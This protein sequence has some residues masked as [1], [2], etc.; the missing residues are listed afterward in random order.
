MARYVV[1]FSRISAQNIVSYCSNASQTTFYSLPHQKANKVP[2]NR[3]E[4]LTTPDFRN[5]ISH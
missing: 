5:A 1:A 3:I 2:L 4:D